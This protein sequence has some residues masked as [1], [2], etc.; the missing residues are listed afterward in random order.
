MNQMLDET[1]KRSR[2][3]TAIVVLSFIGLLLLIY[4]IVSLTYKAPSDVVHTVPK[5]IDPIFIKITDKLNIRWYAVFV[6]GGALVCSLFGYYF[7][8]RKVKFDSDTTTTG[9]TW[10]IIVGV[11][12]GRIYYMSFP[13]ETMDSIFSKAYW[14][15]GVLNG[16]K[17]LFDL[18][19]GGLAIHGSLLAV[20]IFII[21]YC[22]IKKIKFLEL[23][24]IVLPVFMLAQALGRWGNFCNHEA[25]GPLVGGYTKALTDAELFHQREILRHMLVPSFV[26]DNMYMTNEAI[27]GYYYPTFFFE[28]VPNLIGAVGF[29]L[30]RKHSKKLYVGDAIGFYGMWYGVLRFLI[31]IL[32]TDALPVTIFGVNF[33]IAQIQSVIYFTLGLAFI[34]LRRVFKYHLVSSREFLYEG[35]IIWKGDVIPPKVQKVFEEEALKKAKKEAL[36]ASK[37]ENINEEKNE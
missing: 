6:I 28:S 32:R 35:G 34:I 27:S 17:E 10:G 36:K 33:K 25:Y 21:I 22:Y 30:I 15:Q 1:D 29:I 24:E 23:I 14:Q 20:I 2:K 7:F 19:T 3:I 31:E 13:P 9:V 18:T 26:I 37:C 11:L 16:L 8:L 5:Q 12:G 4:I